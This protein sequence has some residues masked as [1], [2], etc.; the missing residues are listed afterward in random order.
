MSSVQYF[1][2][3]ANFRYI[4]VFSLTFAQFCTKSLCLVV[5]II[6]VK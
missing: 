1:M 2:Q 3:L 6:S 5:N 4:L